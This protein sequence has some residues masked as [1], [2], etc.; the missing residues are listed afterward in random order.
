MIMS[1]RAT[2]KQIENIYEKSVK[3]LSI[4]QS[5][6]ASTNNVLKK[7]LSSLVDNFSA[8]DEYA[9][10]ILDIIRDAAKQKKMDI[11]LIDARLE[12]LNFLTNSLDYKRRVQK[13]SGIMSFLRNEIDRMDC[14]TS[15]RRLISDLDAKNTSNEAASQEILE[16]ISN[17]IDENEELNRDIRSLVDAVSGM[18]GINLNSHKGEQGVNIGAVIAELE[19]ATR[20]Q[21]N[22]SNGPIQ[23]APDTEDS[24]SQKNA[25]LQTLAAL[26]LLPDEDKEKYSGLMKQLGEPVHT[27]D[28][29]RDRIRNTA[30]LVNE[31]IGNLQLSNNDL[32]DFIEKINGQLSEIKK[33]MELTRQDKKEAISR[34]INLE[35]S[36]SSTV[37]YIE[38]KVSSAHD[39][40]ELKQ[41]ISVQLRDIREKVEENK[42]AEKIKEE[43]S[44]LGYSKIISELNLTQRET[45]KLK[46]ELK[47]SKNQLLRDTLTGLPNRLAFQ[48][49]VELECNRMK[50][51]KTPLSLAMWDIDHFKNINDSY[52]HDAGDRVLKV[53]SDFV[54]KRLRKTDLFARLGGE[55]FV[56]LMPDT[57]LDMA[58]ILNNKIRETLLN[59]HFTYN[60][61]KF[62]VTSSVGIAEFTS[63]DTPDTVMKR[64]DQALYKSKNEG[65]NRCTT[66]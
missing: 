51:L 28:A 25:I 41:D 59:C 36:V 45:S 33:Y 29:L 39:V 65:R 53:F 60:S 19:A 23:N 62:I 13:N 49:R 20:D 4:T 22:G 40:N 3:L 52:G 12:E 31:S 30:D 64:A 42:R 46:A 6:L 50:R 55:E 54:H 47:E 16:T 44:A 34:S 43:I 9:D 32:H 35:E 27:D 48:E 17:T 5:K 7:S 21:D 18:S 11:D 26:L 58:L 10:R 24:I 15:C 38:D 8:K 2:D 57:S 56:L 37:T 61:E 1:T 66:S 63:D 14:N